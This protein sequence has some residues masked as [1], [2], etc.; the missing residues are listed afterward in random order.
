LDQIIENYVTKERVDA[1][2]RMEQEVLDN[3]HSFLDRGK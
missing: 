1:I 2:N 3:H